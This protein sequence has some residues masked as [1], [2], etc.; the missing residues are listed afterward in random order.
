VNARFNH[1]VF[2]TCTFD[3]VVV[4]HPGGNGVNEWHWNFN[5]EGGSDQ[6]SFAFGFPTFGTKN[7]QLAVSNGVCVD[8][9]NVTVELDNELRAGF[10]FPA[11][12]CPEDAAVF[13]D[14]SFGK[15][16]NWSWDF[17]NTNSSVGQE[18]VPQRYK[19]PLTKSGYF[20]VRLIVEN[21]LHCFDTVTHRMEV[22]YSCYITVPNAFTPNGDGNNDYLYPLN[23]WKAQR[24]EFQVYNR[25]GQQVFFTT[26]WQRKW[27][28]NLN[29]IPQPS[30]AF[31]WKL[32]YIDG[33]T[34]Q[35]VFLKGVTNLIR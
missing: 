27:D 24:L 29:G 22:V 12:L 26:N 34:K 28:G 16:I 6:Q 23:A 3:T 30:G 21:D 2:L 32:S 9:A 7:I 33:D 4:S 11:V 10:M 35:R 14:T 5:G 20:N 1:Q 18:P 15:I 13:K 17:G 19:R 31:V 25:Y 8:T